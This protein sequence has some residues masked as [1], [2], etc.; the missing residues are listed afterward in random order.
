[1]PF[2][3]AVQ[4]NICVISDVNECNDGSHTCSLYATCTNEIGGF[5]CDCKGGFNANG[6]SCQGR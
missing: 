6:S 2:T 1:M 3:W 4:R 5:S